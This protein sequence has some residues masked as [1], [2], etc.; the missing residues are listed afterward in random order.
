MNVP[1][2]KRCYVCSNS[3]N[4]EHQVEMYLDTG[5]HLFATTVALA[6]DILIGAFFLQHWLQRCV[7]EHDTSGEEAVYHGDG[8][9]NYERFSELPL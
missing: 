5:V 1:N 4:G 9:L 6:T 8:D 7:S 3:G 2:W